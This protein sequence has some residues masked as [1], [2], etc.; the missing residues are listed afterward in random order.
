VLEVRLTGLDKGMTAQKIVNHFQPDFT[1]CIG[2]DTTDE[3]MFKALEN[4]AHT[5]RIGNGATSAN[6]NILTQAEV[7]PFLE[8]LVKTTS[9]QLQSQ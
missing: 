2:D 7:L 6:Y 4:K 8:K 5:V 3:D 9:K 1:L